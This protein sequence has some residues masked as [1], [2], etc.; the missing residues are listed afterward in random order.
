SC[1]GSFFDSSCAGGVSTQSLN[2]ILSSPNSS[3]KNGMTQIAPSSSLVQCDKLNLFAP[4]KYGLKYA[5]RTVLN[6]KTSKA[7]SSGVSLS[8]GRFRAAFSFSRS[9]PPYKC[10]KLSESSSEYAHRAFT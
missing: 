4:V 5:P 8:N 1:L 9:A 10:P 7:I 2:V 6:M 3:E